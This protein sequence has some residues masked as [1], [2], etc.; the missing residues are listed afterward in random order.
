MTS[1]ETKSGGHTRFP[2]WNEDP[3]DFDD[4]ELESSARAAL[5]LL[6]EFLR[7]HTDDGVWV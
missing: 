5:E 2:V 6:C 1:G 3:N 7:R 4:F